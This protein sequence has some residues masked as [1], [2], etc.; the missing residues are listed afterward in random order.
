MLV[1]AKAAITVPRHLKEICYNSLFVLLFWSSILAFHFSL[2]HFELRRPLA[3]YNPV[4][5]VLA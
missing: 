1:C 2:V 3:I 4:S 5:V